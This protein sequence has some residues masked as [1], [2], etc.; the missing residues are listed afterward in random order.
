MHTVTKHRERILNTFEYIWANPETGYREWKTHAYLKQQFEELGYT[1]TEAGTVPGFIVDI[2]TGREGPTVGIFAEMDGLL[3]PEHPEAD[4]E[5]GAVHACGHVCQTASLVGVAAALKEPHALDGLSGK[6]R[7]IAVPAE[8]GIEQEYR[9]QLVDEGVIYSHHGKVEFLHRG[10]LDGVEL[11]FMVHTD[12]DNSHSGSMNG[13]SNGLMGKVVTFKGVEAHAGGNPHKGINAL[14]AANLALS[15]IN[16]LRETFEDHKHIRVHPIITEGGTAVNVIPGKVTLET[17][18][19]GADMSAVVEANTKINRAIAASAAAMGA[20]VHIMD[21][22]GS[23]PRWTDRVMAPVFKQAMEDVLEH[24][25]VGLERWGTGCSDMGDMASLM[26]TI[27]GYVGGATGTEHGSNY[28]IFDPETA[29]VDSAKVQVRAL[30]LLL[31]NGAEKAREAVRQYQ[32]AFQNKE[33][34]FA[35]KESLARDFEA[36]TYTEDGQVMLKV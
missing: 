11:S 8:E 14:Y 31:E 1:V 6:I 16:A 22:P 27:H 30:R 3:I 9:Q 35:Y 25:D 18:V 4:K 28:R 10:L 33:A 20:T 34:Y 26:P 17:F 15:A 36:V 7:L 24:V 12:V 29:C 32:P 23:W 2:D 21:F 19:R 5:T 13:G